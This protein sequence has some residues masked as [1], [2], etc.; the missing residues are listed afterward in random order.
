LITVYLP[1]FR[2]SHTPVCY[3]L[4]TYRTA[5]AACHRLRYV[6]YR[7]V[8]TAVSLYRCSYVTAVTVCSVT[9]LTFLPFRLHA[10]PPAI[11][12]PVLRL[13]LRCVVWM[14]AVTVLPAFAVPLRFYPFYRAPYLR[15]VT[16]TVAFVTVLPAPTA[17]PFCLRYRWFVTLF[18]LFFCRF[19]VTPP[20]W[21]V[22]TLIVCCR[23]LLRFPYRYRCIYV[24][25]HLFV[26]SVTAITTVP[27]LRCSDCRY[28]YHRHRAISTVTVTAC[29]SF[30]VLRYRAFTVVLF[31]L[32]CIH[33]G[34][35]VVITVDAVLLPR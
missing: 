34:N 21:F 6:D 30:T 10:V 29:H 31:V 15:F 26:H 13:Y 14:P 9:T 12:P 2:G 7:C 27:A 20:A 19:Y 4:P 5:P 18:I 25:V 17:T 33:F 32:Q 35:S 3:G 28:R 8:T 23:F 16:V 11:L 1:T 22:T 24:T